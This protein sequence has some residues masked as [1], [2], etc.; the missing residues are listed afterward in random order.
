[1]SEL[2]QSPESDYKYARTALSVCN[3]GDSFVTT[4]EIMTAGQS[5]NQVC[6]SD[7]KKSPSQPT[8]RHSPSSRVHQRAADAPEIL[9][10]Y[11]ADFGNGVRYEFLNGYMN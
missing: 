11:K 8:S 7:G 6:F 1:M 10:T 2:R 9:R 5:R 4:N 3:N